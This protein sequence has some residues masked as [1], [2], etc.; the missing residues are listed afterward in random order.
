MNAGDWAARFRGAEPRIF[1]EINNLICVAAQIGKG[2][3]FEHA[4][5]LPS[6]PTPSRDVAAVVAGE[7]SPLPVLVSRAVINETFC[8]LTCLVVA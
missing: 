1:A 4:T 7:V 2:L 6:P 3:K 8:S 5:G